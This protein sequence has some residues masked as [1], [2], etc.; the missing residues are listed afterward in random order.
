M[1][2]YSDSGLNPRTVLA[3]ASTPPWTHEQEAEVVFIKNLKRTFT[4]KKSTLLE[5]RSKEEC[6]AKFEEIL[7]RENHGGLHIR[8]RPH[9]NENLVCMKEVRGLDFLEI[10]QALP[11]RTAYDCK[12]HYANLQTMKSQWNALT[13]DQSKVAHTVEPPRTAPKIA[14]SASELPSAPLQPASGQGPGAI[15][16]ISI[17]SSHDPRTRVLDT[18]RH[19]DHSI[20]PLTS[21]PSSLPHREK[22]HS[23]SE[24]VKT[25]VAPFLLPGSR[26]TYQGEPADFKDVDRVAIDKL[27]RGARD[28]FKKRSQPAPV[29]SEG[30]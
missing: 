22:R 20:P 2:L 14:T 13:S 23:S 9:E 15:G 18:T 17:T 26:D 19:C 6:E 28:Y 29:P 30:A 27:N 12:I 10:S 8:W 4:G 21:A 1:N 3:M 25:T 11:G 7:L 16:D 5:R 24:P